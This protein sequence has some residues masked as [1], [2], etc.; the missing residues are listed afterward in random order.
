MTSK[1][2]FKY[3]TSNRFINKQELEKNTVTNIEFPKNIKKTLTKAK[4]NDRHEA[5]ILYERIVV[6]EKE[7]ECLKNEV[8]NQKEIIKTLLTDEK[9]TMNNSK[10]KKFGS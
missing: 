7:N 1:E 2:L 5:E 3:S 10:Q 4:L 8:K 6:L 9:R